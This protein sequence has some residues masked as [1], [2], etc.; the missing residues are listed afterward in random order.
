MR[1]T[2]AAGKR[3]GVAGHALAEQGGKC[4]FSPNKS[5]SLLLAAPSVPMAQH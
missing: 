2:R 4:A 3:G 5:R 1:N